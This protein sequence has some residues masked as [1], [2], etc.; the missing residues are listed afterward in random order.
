MRRYLH[1]RG[2]RKPNPL[3]RLLLQILPSQPAHLL[4]KMPPR[5]VDRFRKLTCG[6]VLQEQGRENSTAFFD[7]L[8]PIRMGPH[9]NYHRSEYETGTDH[10]LEFRDLA[11]E[12]RSK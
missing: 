12:H 2:H 3:T 8:V 10:R 6:R 9:R 11:Q 4:G 5:F 1:S 7:L